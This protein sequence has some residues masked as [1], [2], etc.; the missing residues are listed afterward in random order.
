MAI[1]SNNSSYSIPCKATS[2][3][4]YLV[5]MSTTS[6]EQSSFLLPPKKGHTL[7]NNCKL[8]GEGRKEGP[9][10]KLAAYL[11]V[12]TY[13]LRVRTYIR[14]RAFSPLSSYICMYVYNAHTDICQN[15]GINPR[16]TLR[17]EACQPRLVITTHPC[18]DHV[19]L[20][21]YELQL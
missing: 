16:P 8:Q 5:H 3:C 17:N 20:L 18:S 14:P 21:Q 10:S 2:E 12:R 6:K 13:L 19:P 15:L 9:K 4:V 7:H 1:Y 11:R